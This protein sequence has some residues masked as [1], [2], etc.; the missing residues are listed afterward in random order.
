MEDAYAR[1]HAKVKALH[2]EFDIPYVYLE[3]REGISNLV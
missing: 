1:F 2:V 3:W